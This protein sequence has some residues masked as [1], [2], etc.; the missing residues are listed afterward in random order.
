LLGDPPPLPTESQTTVSRGRRH[1]RHSLSGIGRTESSIIQ[2]L[3][4]YL[5]N[6]PSVMGVR[7]TPPLRLD[8]VRLIPGAAGLQDVAY[9]R[10]VQTHKGLDVEG[11]QVVVTVRLGS[12]QAQVD[13][14]EASLF[15]GI[16]SNASAGAMGQAAASGHVRSRLGTLG[17]KAEIQA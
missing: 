17:G 10:F 7:F 5:Q 16:R 6:N 9:V 8:Y 2:G 4:S 3:G 15:P 14:V 13:A 1:P 11:S 12:R